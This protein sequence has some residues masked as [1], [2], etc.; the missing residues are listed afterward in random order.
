MLRLR[1]IDYYSQLLI[2][3]LMIVSMPILYFY[4]FLAGLLLLGG[5]Q[6][7][8]AAL[9]TRAYIIHSFRKQIISYWTCTAIILGIIALSLI[10]CILFDSDDMQ[11]PFWVAVV[12]AVPLSY[13]YI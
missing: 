3:I 11:V 10:L 5:W 8:S 7:L 9:N 12:A 13:Y 6:L 4:G 1:Q 2:C